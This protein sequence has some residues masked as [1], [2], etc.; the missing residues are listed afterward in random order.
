MNTEPKTKPTA[1][2]ASSFG[3]ASL[4]G[5][6]FPGRRVIWPE[7][8]GDVLLCSTRHILDMIK[9]GIISGQPTGLPGRHAYRI[10]IAAVI[11]F[12]NDRLTPP[13][14]QRWQD[15]IVTK[16]QPQAGNSGKGKSRRGN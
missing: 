9:E 14:R 4:A 3:P 8:L 5:K 12:L 16:G 13:R 1:P 2:A 10:P 7:E 15:R 11:A 6:W